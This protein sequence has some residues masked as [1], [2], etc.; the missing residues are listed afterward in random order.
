MPIDNPPGRKYPHKRP[1]SALPVQM[2]YLLPL[3]WQR[4]TRAVSGQTR[5]YCRGYCLTSACAGARERGSAGARE[6][7]SAGARERGSA[8]A[9]ER[10]SAHIRAH[11]EAFLKNQ[12]PIWIFAWPFW[13]FI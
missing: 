12:K 10:G 2:P 3:R 1:L 9:R 11:T 8:G 7:G 13:E 6:R 4:A 5:A